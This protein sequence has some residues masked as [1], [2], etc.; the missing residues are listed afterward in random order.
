MIIAAVHLHTVDFFGGQS[1]VQQL[2]AAQMP[3]NP[4]LPLTEDNPTPWMLNG[5]YLLWALVPLWAFDTELRCSCL[6]TY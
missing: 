1:A 4:L 6:T 2:T 5:P 3:K